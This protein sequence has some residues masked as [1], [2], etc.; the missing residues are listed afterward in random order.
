M[1]PAV[2]KRALLT[3]STS[4]S[5]KVNWKPAASPTEQVTSSNGTLEPTSA[6]P[7]RGAFMKKGCGSGQPAGKPAGG[8]E[9]A[10]GWIPG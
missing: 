6:I 7:A 1:P 9:A 3:T 4:W 8:L 10:A 5:D 2:A